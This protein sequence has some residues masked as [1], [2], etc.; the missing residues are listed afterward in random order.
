MRLEL[1]SLQ[2]TVVEQEKTISRLTKENTSLK[3]SYKELQN[4][5]KTF[6]PKRWNQALRRKDSSLK[7]WRQRY[8]DRAR[9]GESTEKLQQKVKDLTDSAKK[10][11]AAKQK[12][13]ERY[14]NRRV[15]S[16]SQQP[17]CSDAHISALKSAKNAISFLE[18]ELSVAKASSTVDSATIPVQADGKTYTKDIMIR[19]ASYHLQSLGMYL[20]TLE[21]ILSKWLMHFS[22]IFLSGAQKGHQK[23]RPNLTRV[24]HFTKKQLFF[25]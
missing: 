16:K 1:W 24:D 25:T 7:M 23:G 19:E 11:K 21:K 10:L 14:K 9:M 12:Q 5:V 8:R 13:K 2:Q 17:A 18:D 6:C 15:P 22:H 4:K 20:N 3:K